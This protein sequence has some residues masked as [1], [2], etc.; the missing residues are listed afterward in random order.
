MGLIKIVPPSYRVLVRSEWNNACRNPKNSI[1]DIANN[2]W[3]LA[4]FLV[5]I[6]Q[7]GVG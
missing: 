1:W 7:Q 2:Q 4:I 6:M 5:L 3:M